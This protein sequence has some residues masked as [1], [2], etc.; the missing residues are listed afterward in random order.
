MIAN[1]YAP[2]STPSSVQSANALVSF[3]VKRSWFWFGVS[4]G[5][6]GVAC[7]VLTITRGSGSVTGVLGGVGSVGCALLG[8]GYAAGALVAAARGSGVAKLVAFAVTAFATN[9]AMAFMGFFFGILA[10]GSFSRGRQLRRFGRVLLPPLARKGDWAA[11]TGR[12]STEA[13]APLA[14]QWRE[15]GR[16]EHASVGAFARLT[17]D[18]LALGAPPALVAAAQRDALDEIAHT[19]ACFAL[20]RSID[21]VP[22]SPGAF[23]QASRARTL[24]GI[25]FIALGELAVDSLVDGA[26]HEGLSAR[27]ISKLA[28][29]CEVPEIT[30]TLR[31]LAADEG[32]HAAHGWDVVEWCVEQGGESV[33]RALE[34]ALR[35]LP[36]TMRTPLPAEAVHGAWERWGIPGA[37]LE[38]E[39]YTATRAYVV[40]RVAALA[41]RT[42]SRLRAA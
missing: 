42:R 1:P 39:E 27:V 34:G 40:K 37:E 30:S 14:A 6:V 28:R 38:A 41:D 11:E 9:S 31:R 29:R 36:E 21:G 5:C 35:G 23:P 8:C 33:L 22:S 7:L 25:R 3:R 10:S 32:R 24:S 17:L 26:L 13:G 16:T 18:L 19:E 4:M 15:N 20:A 12:L 2:P